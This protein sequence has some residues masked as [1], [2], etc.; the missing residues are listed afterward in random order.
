STMDALIKAGSADLAGLSDIDRAMLAELDAEG[1][2]GFDF[3]ATR[4]KFPSGG[5]QAFQTSDGDILRTPINML[6]LVV[7]KTRAFWPDSD[8]QGTPPLCTSADGLTGSFN[9]TDEGSIGA[10]MGFPTVHPALRILQDPIKAA[11]PH[12]CASCPLNAYGTADKGAGKAC[13]E[14][15]R[16]LVF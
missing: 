12:I 7:Q 16:A 11:G 15:R 10:A 8:T 13:K 9:V 5:L 6:F 4:I 3:K 2:A 1:S 14:L